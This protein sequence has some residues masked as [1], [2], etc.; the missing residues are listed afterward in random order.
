MVSHVV[1]CSGGIDSATLATQLSGA[2][3]TPELCFVDYGQPAAGGELRSV[4]AIAKNLGV[5]VLQTHVAGLDVPDEGEITARNLM[6]VTLAL[7]MRP[8]ARSIG[9]GIHAGTGYRD[10]S[11]GFVDLAQRALDFHQDGA[12]RLFA[13]FVDW[14]KA[15]VLAL[16]SVLDVPID[17]THSCET[18]DVPCGTCRSCREREVLLAG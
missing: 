10:C 6:L 12:C 11:S 16:A 5:S 7:A 2:G 3:E 4:R 18:G 13:P 9:L 15:D 1:L 14:S 17:L 8:R